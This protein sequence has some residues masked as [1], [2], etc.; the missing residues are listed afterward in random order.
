M[1]AATS[2]ISFVTAEEYLRDPAYER[3]E[4]V[5]GE[6]LER[7]MGDWKHN[8]LQCRI[9]ALLYAYAKARGYRAGTELTSR[10]EVDGSTR[11]RI[12]DA[13]LNE[14]VRVDS[15]RHHVG[16]PTLAVE[17]LPPSDRLKSA[18]A[19]AAEYLEN[20]SKVV[21]LVDPDNRSVIIFLP[22][23]T[24]KIL[25]IGDTLSAS[26]AFEG[27]EISLVELFEDIQ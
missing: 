3:C 2:G 4:Y 1:A 14:V 6:I 27:L 12:P 16:A 21:W 25:E 18:F 19:K 24:P 8:L 13:G 26:P 22:H 5:D 11:Y 10:M 7:P 17:I 9:A 20:G 23:S 15:R